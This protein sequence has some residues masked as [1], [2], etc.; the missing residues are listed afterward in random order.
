M[1]VQSS[2]PL[3]A[4]RLV[5]R[6]RVGVQV[7][8]QVVPRMHA[9]APRAQR[10]RLAQVGHAQARQAV[11]SAVGQ[12]CARAPGLNAAAGLGAAAPWLPQGLPGSHRCC[13]LAANSC[14]AACAGL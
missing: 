1:L 3:T 13:S 8:R 4:A 2:V 11:G 5:P 9:R 12:P 6:R 7:L 14:A 10:A